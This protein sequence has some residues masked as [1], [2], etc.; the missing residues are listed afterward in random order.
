MFDSTHAQS[1]RFARGDLTSQ[2]GGLQTI[3][4]LSG[5]VCSEHRDAPSYTSLCSKNALEWLRSRVT[6]DDEQLL[7]ETIARLS[8][9]MQRECTLDLNLSEPSSEPD[10]R[11]AWEYCQG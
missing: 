4:T 8:F 7:V 2:P 10:E 11:T 9:D 6:P 3:N 5:S 1:D